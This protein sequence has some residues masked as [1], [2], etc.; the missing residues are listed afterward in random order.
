MTNEGSFSFQSRSPVAG[1]LF[2]NQPVTG[3]VESGHLE[4][5]E[6]KVAHARSFV[7]NG[8]CRRFPL[9]HDHKKQSLLLLR[10]HWKHFELGSL[11]GLDVFSDIKHRLVLP[12][13]SEDELEHAALLCAKRLQR[14]AVL[15]DKEE[16]TIEN[17]TL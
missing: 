2:L 14:L 8:H 1:D 4:P 16:T 17:E 6:A 5:K 11:L 3:N 10:L 12:R 7:I 13:R 9:R 15:R